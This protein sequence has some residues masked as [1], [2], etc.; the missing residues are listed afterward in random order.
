MAGTAVLCLEGVLVKDSPPNGVPVW[1][2][3]QVYH[4][5]ASQFRLVLD[6]VHPDITDV[7]HWCRVNGLGRHVLT[8]CREPYQDDWEESE[9]R[10][11][12]LGEWR[13]QG[14]E[15]ALYVTA[16]P[17][18]VTTM[19]A[20]GVPA[21][22]FGHPSYARPEHRPDHR[23]GM[24]AWAEIEEEV[25]ATLEKRDRPLRVDAEMWSEP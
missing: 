12:H 20:A 22:L 8:L 14:F 3:L 9:V 18:V 2:G 15:V 7:E 13:G 19:M 6:T 5:L 25:T 11:A 10:Q 4:G 1:V 16:N 17:K 24:R 23:D 21:M